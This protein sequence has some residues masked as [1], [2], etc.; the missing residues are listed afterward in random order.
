MLDNLDNRRR[1]AALVAS[2]GLDGFEW[3]G[4]STVRS[5]PGAIPLASEV[6]AL[7][8]DLIE[9]GLNVAAT[10]YRQAVDNYTDGNYE[11]C[12]GQLRSFFERY[13]IV[14]PADL[15]SAATQLRNLSG[16]KKGQSG[17][18]SLE[19]DGAKRAIS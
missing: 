15:Q 18:V 12:N 14:S 13:N 9:L 3:G 4:R 2:L 7:E 8:Q 19:S 11:A 1:S 5:D 6:T 10:H 17:T 16:T